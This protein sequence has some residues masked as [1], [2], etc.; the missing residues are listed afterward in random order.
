[1]K[2]KFMKFKK[3]LLLVPIAL[4]SLTSCELMQGFEDEI[5]IVF[6]YNGTSFIQIM[7]LN[8]KMF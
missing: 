6:E 2:V 5:T 1:M 3:K 7:Q 4:M 8:L